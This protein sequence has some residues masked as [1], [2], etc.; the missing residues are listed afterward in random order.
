MSSDFNHSLKNFDS[1]HSQ[2]ITENVLESCK[3]I[4]QIWLMPIIMSFGLL[5]NIT[6]IVILLKNRVKVNRPLSLLFAYLNVFDS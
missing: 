5:F 4:T 6:S 2:Q 1:N 3:E